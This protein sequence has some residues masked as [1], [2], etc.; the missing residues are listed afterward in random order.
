MRVLEPLVALLA[1][2]GVLAEP[3]AEEVGR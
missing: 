3:A 2:S 1:M